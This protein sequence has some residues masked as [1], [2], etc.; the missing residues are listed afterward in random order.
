[1]NRLLH[2]SFIVFLLASSALRAQDTHFSQFYAS[3]LTLNPALT[4][5]SD[6]TYRVA[7]IYRNQ[8]RSFT[9]P[10]IT[11]SGSFDIKLMQSLLKNDV[12]AVGGLF[13]GDRSGDGVLTMNTGYLSLSYHKSLGKD[14]N[15][16][17]G[18]GVQGGYVQKSVNWEQLT[19]PNQHVN[20]NFDLSNPNNENIA[21]NK[22]GYFDLN[23][24]ILH[25]SWIKPGEVGIF[26][27]L[28]VAHLTSPKESFYSD[29]TRLANRFTAHAGAYVKIAKH[30]YIT[31]NVL[32]Q[33]QN[34]ALETNL[35][36]GFEYHVDMK[37][38]QFIAFVGIWDRINDAVIASGGIEI[39]KVRAS[40][41]YDITTSKL[42]DATQHRSA[43]EIA[44]VYTGLIKSKDVQYPKLVPCPRM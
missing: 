4:G 13:V 3:P 10:Y 24:G 16:F 26:T 27:G 35:G 42:T 23:V 11:Y 20:G 39:Y 29:N 31:P 17:I 21:K 9:T 14:H 33:Y 28:T 1:L 19:F 41:A 36:T 12:F 40:F 5:I 6:G 32:F 38:T 43:F 22:V 34:K 18:I 25:Q 2:L 44:L 8:D 7:G 37:K 15:H 30:F